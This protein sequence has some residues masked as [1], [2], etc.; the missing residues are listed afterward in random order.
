MRI[1]WQAGIGNGL[2]ESVRTYGADICMQKL[3]KQQS[4][5]RKRMESFHFEFLDEHGVTQE[6]IASSEEVSEVRQ[7]TSAARPEEQSQG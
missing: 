1:F 6:V 5:M 4:G 7:Q 2:F 3:L